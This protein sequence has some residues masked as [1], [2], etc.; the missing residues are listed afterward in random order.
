MWVYKTGNNANGSRLWGRNGDVY[1]GIITAIDASGNLISYGSSSNTGWD[2][3]Q[4][5]NIVAVPNNVWKWIVFQRR[6]GTIDCYFHG[7]LYNVT[8]SLW[9]PNLM[10]NTAY[11]QVIGGQAGTNKSHNGYIDEVR[12][13][14]GVARYSG[15]TITVPT[16]S[17]PNP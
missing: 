3:W 11:D 1:D 10:S 4:A 14:K 12:I 17:F 9:T 8:S 5:S 15:A 13:T 6:G 16:S 2:L 7:V